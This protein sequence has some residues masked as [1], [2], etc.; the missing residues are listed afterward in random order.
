M[1]LVALVLLNLPVV[2]R[3]S[4]KRMKAQTGRAR[5]PWHGNNHL[6]KLGDGRVVLRGSQEA[7]EYIQ[8]RM[9]AEFNAQVALGVCIICGGTAEQ[10]TRYCGGSG[11]CPQGPRRRNA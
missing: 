4:G 1:N 5:M 7:A 11:G 8:E 10:G 2:M 3:S 9:Q 6:T